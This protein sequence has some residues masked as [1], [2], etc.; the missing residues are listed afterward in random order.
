MSACQYRCAQ[1]HEKLQKHGLRDFF[2]VPGDDNS[3]FYLR[4]QDEFFD[5]LCNPEPEL[6]TPEFTDF[7]ITH[8]MIDRMEA[9]MM[10]DFR[11]WIDE[12]GLIICGWSA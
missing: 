3:F 4:N 12:F 5:L 9:R 7:L 6:Y 1:W 2:D 8:D 11:A 10:Q